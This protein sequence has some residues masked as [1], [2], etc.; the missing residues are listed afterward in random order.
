MDF[1]AFLKAS[2]DEL[3]SLIQEPAPAPRGRKPDYYLNLAFDPADRIFENGIFALAQFLTIL[4]PGGIG[5]SRLLLQLA[6][7]T[8][9][10]RNFLAFRVSKRKLRWL[11]IQTENSN[12]RIQEDLARFRAALTEEEWA[13]VQENLI[14][15][16]LEHKYGGFA[17]LSDMESKLMLAKAIK[18]AN[19]DVVAFDPLFAF[20][21][22]NL[23]GDEGMIRSCQTIDELAHIANPNTAVVVLH[24]T[25]TGMA[26]IRKAFGH[27]RGSYGRGSKALNSWTRG[28]INLVPG[29]PEDKMKLVI[30]CGKNSNGPEFQPFGVK[31]NPST[32]IYEVDEGFDIDRWKAEIMGKPTPKGKPTPEAI[33]D[34]LQDIALSRKDLTE[35]IM[36]NFGCGKSTAYAA[37]AMADGVTLR[38]NSARKYERA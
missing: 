8:I 34:L 23:N 24:H 31:L 32:M 29:D 19:A 1:T 3:E 38:R 25:L 6:I 4:G 27:E 5:K 10:G 21:S 33:V 14:I 17:G 7:F 2:D 9:I 30:T 15:L 35:L 26:G 28:Q 16:S 11:I 36:D 13:L 37:I 18:E 20:S 12:W 22:G